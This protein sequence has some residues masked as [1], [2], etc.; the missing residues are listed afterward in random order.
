LN[1]LLKTDKTG[2]V[3]RKPGALLKMSMQ[4]MS[5]HNA[6]GNALGIALKEWFLGLRKSLAFPRR[7]CTRIRSSGVRD[8]KLV[9]LRN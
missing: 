9:C 3:D 1:N 7:Q 4:L 8:L 5:W 2:A 6:A